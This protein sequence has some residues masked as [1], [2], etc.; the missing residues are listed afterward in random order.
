MYGLT[1][2]SP[3]GNWSFE[4]GITFQYYLFDENWNTINTGSDTNPTYY[5][6]IDDEPFE[7][8]VIGIFLQAGG[9][10]VEINKRKN[11]AVG[12]AIPVPWW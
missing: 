1:H 5:R 8:S 2:K 6:L 12:I 7:G 3:F 9:L 11:W 4:F 10:W